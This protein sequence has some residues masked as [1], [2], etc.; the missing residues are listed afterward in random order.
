[1]CQ[2]FTRTFFLP[3]RNA[4]AWRQT[5]R[6]PDPTLRKICCWTSVFRVFQQCKQDALVNHKSKPLQ[7]TFDCTSTPISGFLTAEAGTCQSP[8]DLPRFP[9]S[10][11]LQCAFHEI[12]AQARTDLLKSTSASQ[13]WKMSLDANGLAFRQSVPMRKAAT[14]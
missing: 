5:L 14:V 3:S 12:S 4:R 6:L 1:M 13:T 9:R 10:S 7:P 8:V 2:T 11:I